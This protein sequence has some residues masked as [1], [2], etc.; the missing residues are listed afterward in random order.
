MDQKTRLDY[1]EKSNEAI[2][3][4]YYNNIK[5]LFKAYDEYLSCNTP[6]QLLHCASNKFMCA[7]QKESL[8]EKENK[9]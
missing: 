7:S 8:S 9:R 4:E 2:F 5:V 3:Y 1:L 6:F